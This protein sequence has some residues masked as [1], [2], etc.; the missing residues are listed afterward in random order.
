MNKF[1]ETINKFTEACENLLD[2]MGMNTDAINN[3]DNEG[4]MVSP[5]AGNVGGGGMNSVIE[6]TTGEDG[7]ETKGIRIANV[8]EIAR[9]IAEQINGALSIDIPDTQIQLLINGSGG[10]EW[11]ITRY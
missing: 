5:F 8:D 2:A 3:M 9:N 1:T 6:T 7:S 4:G 10:N 11:T